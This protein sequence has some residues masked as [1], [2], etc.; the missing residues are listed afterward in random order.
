MRGVKLVKKREMAVATDNSS[1]RDWCV[2]VAVRDS[3][4][5]YEVVEAWVTVAW[6]GA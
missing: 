2:A 5:C 4:V 6:V 3:Y 1:A